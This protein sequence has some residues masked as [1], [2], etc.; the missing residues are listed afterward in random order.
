[1]KAH[2]RIIREELAKTEESP[3][4][5]LS[6]SDSVVKEISYSEAEQVILKY[7]WLGCM[8]AIVKY[9]YGIFFDGVLGGAV[10]YSTEYSE[11]LGVW[12]KYGFTGKMLLLSRGACAHWTPKN[13]ASHLIMKSMA[14]LP[15]EY[16]VITATVDGLAGEIGTIYQ[17]CNFYHV[18]VMRKS[19]TRWGVKV[20]G[21]LYGSRAIR[22]KIGNQRK[23][24]VLEYFKGHDVEFVPQ[25]SKSR[26][27][28]F[29]GDKR[30]KREHLK[31]IEH[32]LK[33]Y[34]KREE[35]T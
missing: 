17:A 13:S 31:S 34:P 16:E 35:C 4:V 28:L 33:P 27:F 19:K 15:N 29:R 8:P 5:N 14:L 25:L 7:E 21:K 23:E 9:T 24:A 22:S 18:G 2:Q 6:V 12:D 32:L 30:I 3:K 10:V 26:Y 1:M 20:D 11:N